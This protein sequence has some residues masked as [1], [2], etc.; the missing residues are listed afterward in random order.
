MFIPSFMSNLTTRNVDYITV[1]AETF[2][3]V[4]NQIIFLLI[5][6]NHFDYFIFCL[7]FYNWQ[8]ASLSCT[9]RLSIHP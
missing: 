8:M 4:S 7:I 1:I 6:C 3:L 2:N 9:V 5:A